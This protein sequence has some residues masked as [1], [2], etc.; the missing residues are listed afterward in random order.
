VKKTVA[1]AGRLGGGGGFDALESAER[2][3]A[4]TGAGHGHSHAGGG[5]RPSETKQVFSQ[6]KLAKP[7]PPAPPAPPP[8][9]PQQPPQ[10][11]PP[12]PP[13]QLKKTTA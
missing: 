7:A 5:C 4:G 12:P 9:P 11:Q 10:R 13:F 8:Q 3:V 6:H 1:A 2:G